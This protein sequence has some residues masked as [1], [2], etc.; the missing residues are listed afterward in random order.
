[1]SELRKR[2]PTKKD[3]TADGDGQGIVDDSDP[4]NVQVVPVALGSGWR[5]VQATMLVL[6]II[7]VI[8]ALWAA[9]LADDVRSLVKMHV[10]GT[11][12][13]SMVSAPRFDTM[14]MLTEDTIEAFRKRNN[15]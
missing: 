3:D 11:S 8:L 5:C 1:M 12:T 7:N 14:A 15:D 4:N 6:V 10:N 2:K 9:F 13:S